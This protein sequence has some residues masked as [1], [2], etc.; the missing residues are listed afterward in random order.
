MQISTRKLVLALFLVSIL[1]LSIGY[2]IRFESVRKKRATAN[3]LFVFE[4]FE[5]G[6][7]LETSN[8]ITNIGENRTG[9]YHSQNQTSIY[10]VQWISIG[11][12]SGTLQ[13]KTQLDSQYD[14]KKGSIVEWTNNNDFAFNCTYKWTFT[15]TV[16]L[17]CAGGHWN[18]T[19]NSNLY[20]IANFPD[21]AVTFNNNEN[22][23]VRWTYTY[24]CN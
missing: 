14:R 17:D 7:R 12:A 4:T 1:F 2:S 24:N 8:I 9:V 16:K 15:E 6:A 23:T 18:S 5:G 11:N 13:T 10:A 19:G 3:V 22:L 20:S 21:G